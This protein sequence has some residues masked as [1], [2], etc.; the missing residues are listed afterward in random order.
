[1]TIE[2]SAFERASQKAT[3]YLVTHPAINPHY[4]QQRDHLLETARRM[5]IAGNAVIEAART[6][7][8]VCGQ[9]ADVIIREEINEK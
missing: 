5:L 4:W 3:K 9:N 8:R 2:A 6:T 1:M 7:L